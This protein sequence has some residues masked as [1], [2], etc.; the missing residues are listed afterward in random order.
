MTNLIF[1]KRRKSQISKNVA[2]KILFSCENQVTW[3]MMNLLDINW[4]GPK[5]CGVYFYVENLMNDQCRLGAA[6]CVVNSTPSLPFLLLP[7]PPSS[8]P[9]HPGWIGI[10]IS[11]SGVN[12]MIVLQ[13]FGWTLF[14]FLFM[15]SRVNIT[16]VLLLWQAEEP[17]HTGKIRPSGRLGIQGK[18]DLFWTVCWHL[19]RN[20]HPYDHPGC[21]QKSIQGRRI[22]GYTTHA[23]CRGVCGRQGFLSRGLW[24]WICLRGSCD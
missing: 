20:L 13:Q 19:E 10:G 9:L 7:P 5:F 3:M 17:D 24:G 18:Q 1:V 16:S 15:F 21:L 6:L 14:L 2:I 12:G 22:R 8:G 23:V 11:G 4:K